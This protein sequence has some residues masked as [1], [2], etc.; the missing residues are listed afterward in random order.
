MDLFNDIALIAVMID[1]FFINLPVP[2]FEPGTVGLQALMIPLW[3]AVPHSLTWDHCC[4]KSPD[5]WR[6]SPHK[7]TND[8]S[9]IHFSAW[10]VIDISLKL[11]EMFF[12]VSLEVSLFVSPA[13]ENGTFGH[14]SA[15]KSAH[16]QRLSGDALSRW[17]LPTWS[18][19]CRTFSHTELLVTYRNLDTSGVKH[20]AGTS[21]PMV[22]LVRLCFKRALKN[23]WSGHLGTTSGYS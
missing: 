5:K 21:L 4:I 18:P 19:N 15:Q 14:W 23:F 11:S 2:S 8:S 13:A 16:H 6:V 22:N 1:S 12:Q 10:T 3:Q 9:W 7:L 17:N 20:P